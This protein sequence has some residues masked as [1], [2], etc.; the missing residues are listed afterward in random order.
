MVSRIEGDQTTSQLRLTR[1]AAGLVRQASL[2][3]FRRSLRLEIEITG[4]EPS[5]P[6]APDTW[7]LRP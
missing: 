7:Q 6:F 3:D 2:T 1:D 5:G 4:R